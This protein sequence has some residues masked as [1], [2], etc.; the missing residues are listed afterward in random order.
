M[1]AKFVRSKPSDA[2]VLTEVIKKTKRHWG[3]TD[4]EMLLW[5]DELTITSDEIEEQEVFHLI[6]DGIIV[7]LYALELKDKRECEIEH[8][9]LLPDHIGKGFGR[10]LFTHLVETARNSG[11]QT[12]RIVSDP[13]AEQFYVKMG[14]RKV[15]EQ[16]SKIPDRVLPVLELNLGTKA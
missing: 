1:E 8:M 15:G 11:A 6:V 9:W 13:N 10:K 5:D 7:G 3:Y 2:S 12:I 4:E 16:K 14:A